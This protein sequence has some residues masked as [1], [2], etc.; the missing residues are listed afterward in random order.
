[1]ATFHAG[2]AIA[3]N[4]FGLGARPDELVGIGSDPRGWLASQLRGRAPLVEAAGLQPSYRIL[5]QV[6]EMRRERKDS[7]PEL[8]QAVKLNQLYRPIYLAEATAR[9]RH[10]VE[11]PRSFVERLV[12]FWANHFAISAD[13]RTVS[14]IVGAFEREAIRPHVLGK[15]RDMLLAVEQH[16]GMLLYLDN[17]L[18]MGPQSKLAQ[19]AKKQRARGLNENLA[20]EILELHTLGVGGGYTQA[21]VTTFAKV[22]TGWSVSGDVG[23]FGLRDPG[24]FAFREAWH[25][26][27]AHTVL[28]KRYAEDGVK[29]G[30]A[31]LR[32]LARHPSTAQHIATKLARHFVADDPPATLVERLARVFQDT[33][34]DLPT[35][36]RALLD[37]EASWQPVPLKFKTPNDYIVSAYRALE[38][39]VEDNPRT[40]A[41]FDLLGQRPWTP[42]SPAGWPDRAS[43]WDGAAAVFKRVEWADAVAGRL[44]SKRAAAELAPRVLGASLTDA[45]RTAIARADSAAQALTL[46]LIAPEFMRR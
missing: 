40:F 16:P 37:H 20:R 21:D 8:A 23:D 35:L 36:Y 25:E 30:I 1:M 29:Q 27:G 12:F 41:Q 42:G 43:D 31:V 9:M 11:T 2:A 26:P 38:V 17:H 6:L 46:L 19:R 10:A 13:K 33:D 28:G 44:G 5:A 22:I 45:T 3:A 14:G 24:V 34:G 7:E 32:D 15:F 39:P 18:S 4:R